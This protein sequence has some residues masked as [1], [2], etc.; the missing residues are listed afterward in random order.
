MVASALLES[1]RRARPYTCDLAW[2]AFASRDW[3]FES[4]LCVGVAFRANGVNRFTPIV[5]P[6]A[7]RCG[8]WISRAGCLFQAALSDPSLP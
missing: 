8:H 3:A 1:S 2:P 4:C 6:E 5:C 7:L